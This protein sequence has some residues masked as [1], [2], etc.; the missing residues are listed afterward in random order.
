VRVP[1]ARFRIQG[2]NLGRKAMN[3]VSVSQ[4]DKAFGKKLNLYQFLINE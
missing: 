3:V 1:R 4:K 2:R